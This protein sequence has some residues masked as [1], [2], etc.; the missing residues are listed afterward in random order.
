MYDRYEG[1]CLWVSPKTFPKIARH[2]RPNHR[3]TRLMSLK[4]PR[5]G[6]KRVRGLR[7]GCRSLPRS[8][9][10]ANL[11]K[12]VDLGSYSGS[13]SPLSDGRMSCAVWLQLVSMW[14]GCTI[15]WLLWIGRSHSSTAH[16]P[17]R[18]A[19]SWTYVCLSSG[20]ILH[21]CPIP[22]CILFDVMCILA[23]P[24]S[25]LFGARLMLVVIELHLHHRDARDMRWSGVLNKPLFCMAVKENYWIRH[26][27]MK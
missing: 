7:V 6:S 23:F 5:R 16:V 17:V 24:S 25:E 3:Q 20:W 26:V 10:L 2:H 1:T 21:K 11:G 14:L 8:E 22:N 13:L 18:S 15:S 9:S 27:R 12:S 4:N 19:W